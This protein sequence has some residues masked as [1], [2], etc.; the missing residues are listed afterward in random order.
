M[1]TQVRREAWSLERT[2]LEVDV[3]SSTVR[4]KGRVG[5]KAFDASYLLGE[6]QLANLRKM[7]GEPSIRY[8][9]TP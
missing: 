3:E 5:G 9:E 1:R 6:E 8:E 4:L 2:T 7:M